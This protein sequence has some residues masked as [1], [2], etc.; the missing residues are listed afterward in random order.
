MRN[1]IRCWILSDVMMT[2]SLLRSNEFDPNTDPDATFIV[3][4][5]NIRLFLKCFV[6]R[7][8]ILGY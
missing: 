3:R 6:F 1:S 2:I 8:H 4:E 7:V 5:K